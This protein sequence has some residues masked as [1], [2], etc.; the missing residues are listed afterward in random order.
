MY[1]QEYY[2]GSAHRQAYPR[3]QSERSNQACA[4]VLALPLI[5]SVNLLLISLI[6]ALLISLIII[7]NLSLVLSP[8]GL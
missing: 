7:V 2:R 8:L 3:M 6:T 1:S 5:S 4:R